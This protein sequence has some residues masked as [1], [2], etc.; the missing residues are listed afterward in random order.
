MGQNLRSHH[1]TTTDSIE[2]VRSDTSTSGNAPTE[3]ERSGERAL[4]RSGEEDGLEGV[5]HT[6]VKTTVDDDTENG[7]TETTVETGDTVGSKSLLVDVD[8]TVELTLTTLLGRLGVVG[9]T[10]TGIVEGVNEEEGSG[11]GSTT[12]SQVTNHPPGVS[13]TVLLEAEHLLELVTEGKVQGLGREV[14]DDVGG[15]TSPERDGTYIILSIFAVEVTDEKR[16]HTLI[17]KGPLEAVDNTI[18]LAVKTASLDHLIL[19]RVLAIFHI[20]ASTPNDTNLVLNE[21]LDTLDGG[22]SSLGD[23][24][25]DTAHCECMLVSFCSNSKHASRLQA[26]ECYVKIGVIVLKKSITKFYMAQVSNAHPT[27]IRHP[28]IHCKKPL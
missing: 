23:G 6:E 2:R 24:S 28:K 21:E 25:G 17:G 12:G 8:E 11:T 15:V 20:W 4:K 1:H 7:R 3:S 9:E 22:S 26:G 10:G 5:V 27:M 19:Q 18:V 16:L 14:T 13:I